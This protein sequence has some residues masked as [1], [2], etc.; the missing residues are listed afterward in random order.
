MT[1]GI[2]GASADSVKSTS[3]HRL[4]TR[5]TDTN[6]VEYLYCQADGDLTPAGEAVALAIDEDYQV[7]ELTTALALAGHRIGWAPQ[8]TVTDDDYFWARISG[9]FPIRVVAQCA[10]DIQ[11]YTTAT[12][13]ILDDASGTGSLARI[14]GVVITA[15]A[16]SS[17]A[18]GAG[19]EID[20]LV[21]SGGAFV[22][23]V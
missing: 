20:A 5:F 15:A 11:L 6:G 18:S 12:A 8:V 19:L 14:D 10:A 9:T 16:G 3:E 2:I 1:I 23:A 7:T 21:T 4:G 17:S 22:V 13:G